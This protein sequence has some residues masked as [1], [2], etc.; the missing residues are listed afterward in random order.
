MKPEVHMLYCIL[1]IS[2]DVLR[3]LLQNTLKVES[4]GSNVKYKQKLTLTLTKWE[5]TNASELKQRTA[6]SSKHIGNIA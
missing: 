6:Q 1:I 2:Q 5:N 3:Y 4:N